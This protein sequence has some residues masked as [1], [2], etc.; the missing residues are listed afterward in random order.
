MPKRLNVKRVMEFLEQ[1]KTKLVSRREIAILI[2]C[3]RNSI[4]QIER[5]A[6]EKN[7][8]YS[9]IK[10]LS[11]NSVYRLFFPDRAYATI[12]YYDEDYDKVHSELKSTGVN[13][14]LLWNEYKERALKEGKIPYQY[15]QYKEHYYEYTNTK[16]LTTRLEHKPAIECEVDWSGPTMQVIDVYTGVSSK[17]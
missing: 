1:E 9:D 8:S 2:S 10:D 17:A 14:T 13:L 11:D 4:T 15:T 6:K 5:I 12:D 7:I 16:N 3:S